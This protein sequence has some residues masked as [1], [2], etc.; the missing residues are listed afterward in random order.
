MTLPEHRRIVHGRTFSAAYDPAD[1]AGMEYLHERAWR[2]AEWFALALLAC[3]LACVA[4]E[5]L[6]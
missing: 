4:W 6:A 1:Y 2:R 3:V 5:V